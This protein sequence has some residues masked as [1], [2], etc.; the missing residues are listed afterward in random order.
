MLDVDVS[1]GEEE[2]LPSTIIPMVVKGGPMIDASVDTT[3]VD[4]GGGHHDII[5]KNSTPHM[6]I[7]MEVDVPSAI[8]KEDGVLAE[9]VGKGMRTK[10][11][12]IILI[13]KIMYLILY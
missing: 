7:G 5:S 6:P 12:Y 9:I 11:P 4:N 1:L 10:L 13:T 2:L 8:N 3:A